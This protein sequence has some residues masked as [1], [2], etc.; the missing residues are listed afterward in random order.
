MMYE[1]DCRWCGKHMS[2]D[3]LNG[4]RPI[5]CC[6]SCRK[7]ANR[8][9][10]REAIKSP[11]RQKGRERKIRL[12]ELRQQRAKQ[13]AQTE[14]CKQCK[15]GVLLQSHSWCCGYSDVNDH[16]RTSLHP[17]GL[18]E[19]CKEFTPRTGARLNLRRSMSLTKVPSKYADRSHTTVEP[20]PDIIKLQQKIRRYLDD[21]EG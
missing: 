19:D 20:D 7:E 3:W 21:Q 5:Y 17:D 13:L 4:R 2:Y 1:F 10:T 6:A 16:T 12:E 15:W 9:A 14:C 18:T 8:A 11:E